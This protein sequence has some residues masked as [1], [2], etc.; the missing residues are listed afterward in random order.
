MAM[1][2]CKACGKEIHQTAPTCPNC[3][4][5]QTGGRSVKS[6]NAA[7]WWCAILG[8]VG[9]H[10]FYL[11]KTL[12]GVLSL[13]FFP[14][15]I[16]FLISFIDIVRIGMMKPEDWG[17]RYNNG[18]VGP[19]IGGFPKFAAFSIAGLFAVAIIGIVLAGVGKFGG[20]SS[21]SGPSIIE[22][23]EAAD[24][25]HVDA[26]KVGA[27]FNL[28]SEHTDIQRD[29]LLKEI[30]GKVVVWQLKV[31]EVEKSGST[32]KIQTNSSIDLGQGVEAVGTFIRITP[33]DDSERSQI[34]AL[35][36][37]NMITVRGKISGETMR[38]IE[39][40]P[41]VLD[42]P[43]SAKQ[44]Q[45]AQAT[46]TTNDP[47]IT[48]APQIA[49]AASPTAATPEAPLKV[50]SGVMFNLT[51][52]QSYEITSDTKAMSCLLN[53]L[54]ADKLDDFKD[55][56]ATGSAMTSENGFLIGKGCLPHACDEFES[57]F[58]IA[59]D[60]SKCFAAT[61]R[62]GNVRTLFGT[63]VASELPPSLLK[64]LQEKR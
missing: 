32:Y 56:L 55:S 50:G 34:E 53:L 37:G 12:Q 2:F 30:K 62:P 39:L 35:K 16:P 64:W 18:V 61:I 25:E 58:A 17:N 23:L 43:R 52:K 7:F 3:G 42:Q 51:G 29:N 46:P 49:P 24:V 54:G 33:R 47:P 36:T 26:V 4:A 11:G 60:G 48:Q 31:F 27:Y 15:G 10:R 41:A 5:S 9:G 6:Q 28:N 20:P 14:T 19:A 22:E 57:A 1:V 38:H 21:G 44:M 59:A 45:P 63:K 13:L 8:G 40:D